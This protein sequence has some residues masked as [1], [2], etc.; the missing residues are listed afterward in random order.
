M[1]ILLLNYH[2]NNTNHDL[3][4]KIYQHVDYI[5]KLYRRQLSIPL[6]GIDSVYYNEYNEFCQQYK[7]F[8]PLNYTQEYD[9][10][11]K[12]NF[13]QAFQY[14]KQCEKFEQELNDKERNVAIYRKYIQ[15]EKEP[16]RIQCLYERAIGMSL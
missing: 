6:R 2:Q 16:T 7:E 9:L 8:L 13:D 14:L 10:I 5:L 11:I 1:L 12:N 4:E 15:F 3:K